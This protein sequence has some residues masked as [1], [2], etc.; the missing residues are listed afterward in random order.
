MHRIYPKNIHYAVS[1]CSLKNEKIKRLIYSHRTLIREFLLSNFTN[2][3]DD[4]MKPYKTPSVDQI[5]IVAKGLH[6]VKKE[7]HKVF[8]NP[9]LSVNSRDPLF[10]I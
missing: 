5:H 4:E 2:Q 8:V 9:P 6:T 7:C 1:Y 3:K 10:P